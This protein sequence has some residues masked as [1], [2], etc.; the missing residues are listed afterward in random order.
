MTPT[1]PVEPAQRIHSHTPSRRSYHFPPG[2]RLNLPFYVFTKF[3]P[4]DPIGLFEYLTR[5]YGDISHY[6]IGRHH[7]IFLN[8]PEYIR[9]VLVVQNDNFTKERTVRRTKMLLGEGMITA[10]GE[11]HRT[12]RQIAQPAFHRQRIQSYSSTIVE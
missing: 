10:E 4:A 8:D 11:L 3:R 7:I 5:T 6:K 9:E 12:Q 1:S 2:L